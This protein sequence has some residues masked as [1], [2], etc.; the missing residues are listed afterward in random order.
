M[1]RLP[2]LA[3]R[4]HRLG[5]ILT[6]LP[7]LVVI[8]TGLLLQMKKDWSWVQPPTQ[9]G[10]AQVPTLAFEAVLDAVRQ[11]PEAEVASWGDIDRLDV[12]PSKGMLKVRCRNGIE[13]Q[14]DSGSAAVLLVAER[15]S[16]WLESLHDGSWF[17]PWMKLGLFL[18]VALVV[19]FLWVSGIYL[20]WLPHS[21]RRRRRDKRR[22]KN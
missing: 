18:P 20:W 22:A 2:R 13:V 7:F 8:V 17:H 9:R 3:R 16:D 4:W 15:R 12:R 21:I 1:A 19:L 10:E 11:V 14:L 6:A 5:A